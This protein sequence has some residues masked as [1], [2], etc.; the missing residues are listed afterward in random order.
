MF[1]DEKS[2][3]SVDQAKDAALRILLHNARGPFQG[4]PRAAGWGYPEPYTRD[5]MISALGF[6]A[7]GSEQLADALRRTLVALAAN[8]TTRGLIPSPRPRS[9]R[10]WLQR[11]HAALP[12]WPGAVQEIG[13]SAGL[14]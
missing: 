10:P 5:L 8:Q 3:V 1:M 14:P 2:L 7:S 11:Y 4:L 13:Q 12:L 9:C 6:L